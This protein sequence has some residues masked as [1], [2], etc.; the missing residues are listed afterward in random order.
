M[1]H[2]SGSQWSCL[3]SAWTARALI[4]DDTGQRT[5]EWLAEDG[6]C[7]SVQYHL[8]NSKQFTIKQCV[9]KR[10]N[11]TLKHYGHS[12]LPQTLHW[13]SQYELQYDN[14]FVICNYI[15]LSTADDVLD[16]R[17]NNYT[18][19][20]SVQKRFPSILNM[21]WTYAKVRLLVQL[22]MRQISD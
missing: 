22:S 14:Q 3:R 20:S 18:T 1:C 8:C 9:H 5:L 15:V 10:D 7:V 4:H 19:S 11:N 17:R 12:K 16:N 13:F 2:P 21:W 6:L